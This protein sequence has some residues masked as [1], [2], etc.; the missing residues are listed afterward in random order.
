MVSK[1]L[2]IGNYTSKGVVYQIE[3]DCFYTS[4]D[5]VSYKNKWAKIHPIPLA[6]GNACRLSR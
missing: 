6:P 3:E 5:G 1:E 4:T 2:R